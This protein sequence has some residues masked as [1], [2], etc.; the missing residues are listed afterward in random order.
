M[1]NIASLPGWAKITGGAGVAALV[2]ALGFNTWWSGEIAAPGPEDSPT[3][4]I[5]IPNGSSAQ[6]IGKQLAEKKII[7]S[8]FAWKL[9]TSVFSRQSSGAK[10]GSYMLSPGKTLPEVA[11]KIWSGKVTE[12]NFQVTPGSDIK[13]M[14]ANFQSAA[15]KKKTGFSIDA[16]DFI[17]ASEQIPRDKFPWLPEGIKNLEGFLYAETYSAP[18]DGLTAKAMVEQ[19]L[20]QFETKALPVYKSEGAKSGFTL[21]QWVTLGSIVEK[22]AVVASERPQI[23]GVFINRLSK[24]IPLASDPTV[25]YA[26][27]L[28]QTP[29]RPLTFKQVKQ[30]HPYNTYVTPGLPPGPIASPGL[31]SLQAVLKPDATDMLFFVARY[32]GTHVFSRTNA[33]HE[34]ATREIRAGRQQKQKQN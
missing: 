31:G 25:Q 20:K 30:P 24:K 18:K 23:A 27:G 1:K 13:Q 28:T 17:A 9:W 26:F 11:G 22:E 19:M 2:S 32:D 14:A 8:E 4:Q 34:K 5:D 10:A 33:E 3:V 29:D 16:K 12:V 7:K 15:F 21:L 6:S